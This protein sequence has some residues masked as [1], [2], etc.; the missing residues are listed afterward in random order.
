M[1]DWGSTYWDPFI[2]VEVR[3]KEE[4]EAMGKKEDRIP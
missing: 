1:N 3:G 4:A 2:Q